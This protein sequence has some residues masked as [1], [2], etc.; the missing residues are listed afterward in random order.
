MYRILSLPPDAG[1]WLRPRRA[2]FLLCLTLSLFFQKTSPSIAGDAVQPPRLLDDRFA[3]ELFASEPDIVTP[4]GIA[5]DTRGQVFVVESHTHMRP[6][7]Y[8]G[9][10]HDRLRLL[11]DTNH[12]GTADR[13]STFYEGEQWLMNVAAH[14]NG[15]L[16]AVSRNELF[17]LRDSDADGVA[18]ERQSLARMETSGDYPH[19]GFLSLTFD[20][21]GN[22]YFGLGQN[23]GAPYI[24][25]GND[26]RS[27]SSKRGDGGVFRC[28]EDGRE[29]TR[30]A[31]GFWNPCGLGF[32]AFGR[33]F[34]V[35]N[36]PGNRPPCRFIEI[37]PGGDFGYRRRA[38]EPFISW[39]GELPGT[40]PMITSTAEAPTAVVAIESS[41]FPSDYRGQLLVSS[42]SEY[43]IDR[44]TV[45]ARDATFAAS[46]QPMI[47]GDGQFRPSD[48]ALAPDGSLFISDWV[49]RSYPVHGR[50][51]VWRVRAKSSLRRSPTA[52][53]PAGGLRSPDRVTRAAAA[54]QLARSDASG[55]ATLAACLTQDEDDR[56][57][58]TALAGLVHAGRVDR[59][60]AEI[61]L[62]HSSSAVR[63]QAVRTLPRELI[64]LETLLQVERNPRVRAAALRRVTNR[65][66][67]P[68]L[69]AALQSDDVF[70]R[71]AAAVG[72]GGTCTI[73]DLNQLVQHPDAIVRHNALLAIR[74]EHPQ[75]LDRLL[76]VALTDT[77]EAVRYLALEWIAENERTDY[78]QR[79]IDDLAARPGSPQ[80]FE[81][82][83]ATIAAV[84]GLMRSWRPGRNGD[85]WKSRSAAY[86]IASD[87][88]HD[89]K[90]TA[91]VRRQVIE[92]L[93]AGHA[94]LT[95]ERLTELLSDG[96]NDLPLQLATVRALVAQPSAQEL[97]LEIAGD[98]ARP[99]NVRAEAVL[100][101]NS[102][103]PA[104][105]NRL[106]GLALDGPT[107]VRHE[108]LR[109]LR[110]G[111]LSANQVTRLRESAGDDP[112][113]VQLVQLLG[114]PTR[115]LARPPVTDTAAWLVRLAGEADRAAG[116]R[117]FFHPQ[118]P[119]C[120]KCHRIDRRGQQVGPN[121]LRTRGVRPT[122][123]RRLLEAILEPSKEIALGYVPFRFLTSDG[124]V[125][126][127]IPRTENDDAYMLYDA[128]GQ[129][130]SVRRTDIEEMGPSDKSL[131]PEGLANRMT[132]KELR[133]VIAY[134]L[135]PE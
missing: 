101:L 42:W 98:E 129:E 110:G 78:R 56:V 116:A 49:D 38:L 132:Y 96:V 5:V 26:G 10:E 58:A 57:H 97:L 77:S 111:D 36:D 108:A 84:D 27:V 123:R 130:F 92:F 67:L 69:V 72:L 16:Y 23:Y 117:V 89:P 54:R 134:I 17:R 32:D 83:L 45:E 14:P 88:L 6:E 114:E 28:T 120:A 25:S 19:N 73:D 91:S 71:Q 100:G 61:A 11:A 18:D 55:S 122:T 90:A 15:W 48:M 52:G 39:N 115:A 40:L 119:G 43:R 118:G 87:L 66:L 37:V 29:L 121:F 79:V 107:P 4:F 86:D 112:E 76:P 93:P 46:S 24:L 21:A 99:E 106:L 8:A 44:Y 113:L 102:R 74:E 53:D 127:G 34:T 104:H 103:E 62:A 94:S 105:K 124:R 128:E 30:L 63:E 82:S 133:D 33:L 35:D 2:L 59:H 3:V 64:A 65:S 12:D 31:L 85:W 41:G 80:L 68:T 109:S 125:H 126:V 95:N 70:L 75:Q 13:A 60:S 135:G 51:R 47:V 50:G 131:M 81:V 22:V 20:F 9:P 1:I 7:D